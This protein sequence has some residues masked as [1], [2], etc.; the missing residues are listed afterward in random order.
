MSADT[1]RRRRAGGLT[2][3]PGELPDNERCVGENRI[4]APHPCNSH[5]TLPSSHVYLR[6]PVPRG[7]IPDVPIMKA[8]TGT[9]AYDEFTRTQSLRQ[10]YYLLVPRLAFPVVNNSSVRFSLI[11]DASDA[12]Q[13]AGYVGRKLPP[14]IDSLPGLAPRRQG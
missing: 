12:L 2:A 1:S 3:D 10:R 8:R 14:S 9:I 5:R 6:T 13:P 11:S 7:P 4:T